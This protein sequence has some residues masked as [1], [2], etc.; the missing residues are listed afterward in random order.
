MVG[1][2][3]VFLKL[4]SHATL[5]AK[6]LHLSIVHFVAASDCGMNFDAVFDDVLHSIQGIYKVKDFYATHIT[7]L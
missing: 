5:H 2:C 3:I 4:N 1:H 7:T 6:K